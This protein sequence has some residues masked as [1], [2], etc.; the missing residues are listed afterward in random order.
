MTDNVQTKFIHADDNVQWVEIFSWVAFLCL[1]TFIFTIFLC[2][3][4]SIDCNSKIEEKS[5]KNLGTLHF[6]IIHTIMAIFSSM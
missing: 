6:R 1:Y 3:E 2:M 5:H 4:N